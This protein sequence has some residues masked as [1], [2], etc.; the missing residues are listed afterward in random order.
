MYVAH[1]REDGKYQSL[2]EHLTGTA[3]EAARFAS[4]FGAAGWGQVLGMF[5]DVGK[6]APAVQRRIMGN[7]GRVDHSTAGAI[8]IYKYCGK[9]GAYCVMGHHGR[10]PDGGTR[11]DDCNRDAPTLRG[12][13]QRTE[14]PCDT[15][16]LGDAS[17][18]PLTSLPLREPTPQAFRIAMFIRMM[19][20]CLVDADRLD[21]ECYANYGKLNRGGYDSIDC[22]HDRLAEYLAQFGTPTNPINEKRTLIREACQLAAALGPG[23][24]SLTV[25]TGG[26]K[27]LASLAFALEHAKKHRYKRVIYVIP[28]VSII[29]Q[30]ADV[31]RKAIGA[32]NVVEHHANFS[33]DD[34]DEW[35]V[36]QRL[37]TENWDAPVIV[38][39]NVQFFES[40]FSAK[41]S[42][43]RKLHNIAE[44]VIIFDEAQ[45]IPMPYLLPCVEAIAELVRNY[46][47]TAVLMSATQPALGAYLPADLPVREMMPDPE[48]LYTFFRRTTLAKEGGMALDTLVDRLSAHDQALCIVN[49]RKLA[50]KLYEALR[51]HEGT[52][53]LS[54]LMY[55]QHRRRV[56]DKIRKRLDDGLPCRVISTSLIEAGV[57]VSFPAVYREEAG[58]DSII[59]A[60][61]RCNREGKNTASDSLVYV[62]TLTGDDASRPPAS[63]RQATYVTQEIF[64][65]H[66]DAA[67]IEAIHAYFEGLY[68]FK[69]EALDQ[70]KIMDM[71]SRAIRGMSIPF[72]EIEKAFT[73]IESNTHP[74]IV[75]IEPE[76][77]DL[78]DRLE[79]GENTREILRALG[80]YT[81]NVYD[82]HLKALHQAGAI[83]RLGED[84][85]VSRMPFG[86]AN[87]YYDE[88]MGLKLSVDTGFAHMV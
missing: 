20:S 82:D 53:H 56:L 23:L 58:L 36:R 60:A 63:T 55:P 33:F 80:T 61:G 76:A 73:L 87:T 15:S 16:V 28:Y 51:E 70:K 79:G 42:Q 1:S 54:T 52:Y 3:E 57:D 71:T 6:T 48:G 19:T 85:W 67:S 46:N 74:I 21:T 47:C 84:G 50:Q 72:R 11:A 10:I 17:F 69:G 49:T 25:P 64:R 83:T 43:L 27:T 35:H 32:H 29:E 2:V 14:L 66:E 41:S 5:H 44:S 9:I 38:T 45:M 65:Q 88:N 34:D 8:A 59:Q 24:F 40:L 26:G 12:R 18:E 31:F 75:A 86:N 78:V 39:T 22:L 81:V 77:I 4:A 68:Q 62:F 7:G 37:S 30:N 13:L